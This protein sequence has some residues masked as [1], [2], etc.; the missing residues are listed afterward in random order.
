MA[1]GSADSGGSEATAP[2]G[3]GATLRRDLGAW[4]LI[5][6]GI[7]NTIGAGIFV[8][9]GTA[10][11]HY[12]GPGIA[13]SY[14]IGGI[15]CLCAG[16]CYAELAAMSPDAGSAYSYAYASLGVTVAWIIGWDLIIE[17]LLAGATVAVGWS[18]FFSGMLQRWHMHIPLAFASAPVGLTASH[19]LRLTGA[20][21]NLPAAA[22]VM[23][24]AALLYA[25]VRESRAFFNSIICLLMA[26]IAAIVVCGFMH[27]DT[28]NWHPFIPPNAGRP[29]QFGWSGVMAAAA[30]VFY[31]YVGFETI[32]TATRETRDPGRNLPIGLLG[33]LGICA[34]LYVLMA[35]V[36]TGLVSYR[37]LGGEQ[38]IV[39]ALEAAGPAL[40]WLVPLVSVGIVIGLSAAS[41]GSMYA[42]I[43]IFYA[44]ASDGLLPPLFAAVHPRSKIPHWSTL[45]VAG[46]CAVTAG[47]LPLEVLGEL[48]SIGTLL[49]FAIVCT[50]VLILRIRQ[51]A[52]ARPFRVM[53]LYLVAPLGVAICGYMMLSLP[54]DTWWRLAIWMAIGL[55]VYAT[56]RG[57]WQRPAPS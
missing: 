44:M 40:S 54:R 48:V 1:R 37:R 34:V 43:R 24:Q 16:L 41:M 17:F 51:P 11:S 46:A 31:S 35:L 12:A 55:V 36:M 33:S 10:A 23:V 30:L 45:I 28:A 50:C 8:L 4:S 42:Q 3:H 49:A 18:G 32:S 53:G 38:P 21:V 13:I 15:A 39:T 27:V 5:A 9:T 47:L 7:S 29:G 22:L 2:E 6:L 52:R 14:V 57:R 56:C 20:W 26:L 25:G 19:Q